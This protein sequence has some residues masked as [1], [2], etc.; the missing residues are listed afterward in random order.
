M[1][2]LFG[3]VLLAFALVVTGLHP[4]AAKARAKKAKP[5]AKPAAEQMVTRAV[6]EETTS[7]KKVTRKKTAK[8]SRKSKSASRKKAKVVVAKAKT[9]AR[10]GMS[11]PERNPLRLQSVASATAATPMLSEPTGA[12]P[13]VVVDPSAQASTV[14]KTKTDPDYA[15]ILRPLFDYPLSEQ[16]RANLKEAFRAAY[17]GNGEA[18]A[19]VEARI[20][21]PSARKFALWYAYRSGGSRATGTEIETFRKA[22]H[23]WPS[24]DL[25]RQRAEA[26]LFLR[27]A[28]PQSVIAFFESANPVT[29]AG[30]AALASALLAN[31]QEAR[32]KSLAVSAWRSHTFDAKIEARFLDKFGSF[33]TPEDHRIRVNRLLYTDSKS[34]IEPAMRTVKLLDAEDKKKAE[35]RVAILKKSKKGGDLIKAMPAETIKADVGLFFNR[36]QWLRRSDRKEEAFKLMLDAP[37]EPD[38]LLDLAEWWIERRLNVRAAL[39]AGQPQVAYE[40]AKNHGPISG[41]HYAD[42]EF[43]AGW[44]ALRYLGNPRVALDHF[45][46]LRTAVTG[47]KAI[48]RAEYWLGRA[49]L[50]LD[51]PAAAKAHFQK[52]AARSS[53]YYGAL[54]RQGV[55]QEAV[56]LMV[57][58]TPVPTPADVD[59]FLSRDAVRAIGVAR[60]ADL[61]QLLPIFFNHL[62][63]TL[64]SPA[65]I[66]LLA[67]FALE[68][69]MR[70]ASIRLS[71]VAFSRGK[72]VAAYA[73]PSDVL[74]D[75]KALN[76]G[77]ESALIHSLSRQESE[78]NASAKSPVGARGL[79]QLMPTTARAVANQYKVKYNVASLTGD[80]SYN[81]QLGA[82]HLRDLVDDYGGSYIL[83]LAA[84]NAGGSRVK[85]WIETFGDPRS[86]NV[87]PVDWVERIPF[88]ET[89]EY[90]QKIMESVQ[91]YRAR[92]E[93][94]RNALQLAQDLYRG[95]RGSSADQ[96]AAA[97]TG[98]GTAP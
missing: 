52:A 64:E 41:E 23:D 27:D 90:V 29:G 79:M 74:P 38:E 13:A 3:I 25:L 12:P 22:H 8:K 46:S 9:P 17:R 42:A 49:S 6:G 85:E 59:R 2:S 4:A 69:N 14:S 89:R 93:G 48:A 18:V 54:A 43:L 35:A 62:A 91:I 65:E 87:D 55:A 1:R 63:R 56:D 16:D 28:D 51:D 97:A 81:M 71:K 61:D 20:Q 34:R 31:G 75:Y 39:N 32:A 21:D 83:A 11:L 72:P 94:P 60:A 47:G 5:P 36:V 78:F 15:A 40:I 96:K 68:V 98:G 10:G 95:R 44:V 58:P 26:A 30:K 19:E 67:E 53:T 76:E 92:L 24:Q 33:L 66:A 73:F 84:Y 50:A 7:V 88:T 37:S 70:Q 80:P 45:L 86:P 82:A 77:V 57:P